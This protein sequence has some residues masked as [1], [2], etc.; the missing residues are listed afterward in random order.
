M[1]TQNENQHTKIKPPLKPQQQ[2]TP[3]NPPLRTFT[4]KNKKIPRNRA[5]A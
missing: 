5:M 1:E 2:Q 3:T 4:H